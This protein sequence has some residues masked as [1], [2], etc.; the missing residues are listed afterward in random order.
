MADP[1]LD[2]D[3]PGEEDPPVTESKPQPNTQKNPSDDQDTDTKE[4]IR[5]P[6]VPDPSAQ[7]TP[8]D[9]SSE[10]ADTFEETA[11][12]AC[13]NNLVLDKR[14]Q[15]FRDRHKTIW[16]WWVDAILGSTKNTYTVYDRR[17]ENGINTEQVS[18]KESLL[19]FMTAKKGS[20]NVM[21][22]GILNK[23]IYW[24]VYQ[25][26]GKLHPII[27][28]K[29]F[30]I[31]YDEDLERVDLIFWANVDRD[32]LQSES[33]IPNVYPDELVDQFEES[34]RANTSAQRVMFYSEGKIRGVV[35]TRSGK[36]K[37]T[38]IFLFS[39][40]KLII[41][42]NTLD[43]DTKSDPVLDVVPGFNFVEFSS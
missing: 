7:E 30:H 5:S 33:N 40:P 20:I 8:T 26:S 21:S 32:E 15:V 13:N 36:E 18:D 6:N 2:I 16:F 27:G 28:A 24:A 31:F 39:K 37:L 17:G 34:G 23:N 43:I 25:D 19:Y 35:E 1:D 42:P 22:D 11:D 9:P 29:Y 38:D 3:E 41:N 12:A 10:E 4:E 14:A